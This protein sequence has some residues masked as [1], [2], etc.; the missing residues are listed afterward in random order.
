[1]SRSAI[2]LLL[3]I[4]LTPDSTFGQATPTDLAGDPL[5]PGAV[6]RIGHTRYRLRGW[7][8]QVFF[9]PDAKTVI[10]KGEQGVI[11]FFDAD[12]GKDLATEVREY[13]IPDLTGWKDHDAYQ[14]A[15]ERLLRDLRTEDEKERASAKG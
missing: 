12:T 1:M 6:A 13:F 8:Q 3:I 14:A 5:P 15:F 9:S 10:A 4:A 7:H 11:R 2:T